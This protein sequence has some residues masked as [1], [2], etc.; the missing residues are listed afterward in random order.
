[1]GF[2]FRYISNATELLHSTQL[3]RAL[4]FYKFV[5]SL[6]GN[7]G[8]SEPRKMQ[9]V[10]RKKEREIISFYVRYHYLLF[11]N[12]TTGSN[13]LIGAWQKKLGHENLWEDFNL[14]YMSGPP[15]VSGIKRTRSR[16]TRASTRKSTGGISAPKPAKKCNPL[17]RRRSEELHYFSDSTLTPLPSSDDEDDTPF[18]ITTIQ[19]QKL[20]SPLSRDTVPHP[21]A[22]PL[23]RDPSNRSVG[24]IDQGISQNDTVQDVH[25][26]SGD[27]PP[28]IPPQDIGSFIDPLHCGPTNSATSLTRDV[29]NSVDDPMNGTSVSAASFPSGREPSQSVT[30]RSGEKSLS[31]PVPRSSTAPHRKKRRKTNWYPKKSSKKKTHVEETVDQPMVVDTPTVADPEREPE[32]PTVAP[33]RIDT[34]HDEPFIPKLVPSDPPSLKILIRPRVSIPPI[35]P[36]IRAPLSTSCTNI[37][38][39]RLVPV[40]NSDSS[41]DV[42]KGPSDTPAVAVPGFSRPTLSENPPIWAQVRASFQSGNTG[43]NGHQSRQEICESCDFFK[44]YQGGVYYCNGY[45]KGYLLSCFG[46]M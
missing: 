5:C 1:M 13:A 38:S 15:P 3:A 7:S 43:F 23:A 10:D 22:Y 37:P 27:E 32:P 36:E 34:T 25:M 6:E 42:L 4:K 39:P 45:A 46:A 21:A 20:S 44:S 9:L 26:G 14:V 8:E 17:P 2:V 33:V 24:S 35:A 31:A 18:R 29:Q 40:P 28:P 16:P 41:L 30:D 11:Q 19:S 12:D